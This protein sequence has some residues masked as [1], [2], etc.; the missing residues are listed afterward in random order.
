MHGAS[1]SGS[2]VL[3]F[4]PSLPLP[5]AHCL[6]LSLFVSASRR[7]GAWEVAFGGVGHEQSG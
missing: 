3:A 2:C 7:N 5:I 4:A 1:R 6:L